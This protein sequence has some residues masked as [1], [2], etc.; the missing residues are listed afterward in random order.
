MDNIIIQTSTITRNVDKYNNYKTFS[1]KMSVKGICIWVGGTCR[2]C[3]CTKL[4]AH[5]TV[6]VY[7]M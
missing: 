4:F 1:S 7:Q 3:T 5:C 2:S 6:L